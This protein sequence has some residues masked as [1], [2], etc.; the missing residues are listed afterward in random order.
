[1]GKLP[2]LTRRIVP[3]A[4]R[5]SGY[6][7][8]SRLSAGFDPPLAADRWEAARQ[9]FEE[10]GFRP[11]GERLYD[12]GGKEVQTECIVRAG[13]TEDARRIVEIARDEG[14]GVMAIGSLTSAVGAFESQKYAELYA[15]EGY[16][17][18]QI[19]PSGKLSATMD[20]E[21]K[22]GARFERLLPDQREL[23]GMLELYRSKD[24]SINHRVRVWAGLT[25]GQINTFLVDKLGFGHSIFLDLTTFDSAQI[26]AVVCN[27]SEGPVRVNAKF[28]LK[29]L[30]LINGDGL[31]VRLDGEKAAMQVG[32]GGTA[33]VVTELVLDVIRE[34]HNEFGYFLPLPGGIGKEYAGLVNYL[35]RVMSQLDQYAI[36]RFAEDPNGLKLKPESGQV[37]LK[38]FEIITR[39][40]LRS[41]YAV[42][43]EDSEERGRIGSL[44]ENMRDTRCHVG[45]LI[46]CSTDIS[47]DEMI[48][49]LEALFEDSNDE[50]N[51][52]TAVR[53]LQRFKDVYRSMDH[54]DDTDEDVVYFQPSE[55]KALKRIR[56]AI[57]EMTRASKLRGFTTSTDVNCRITATDPDERKRAYKAIM[58][59]YW[60]YA[61][62]MRDRDFRIYTYGHMHPGDRE[63]AIGGGIDPHVRASYFLEGEDEDKQ[64]RA[65]EAFV[66]LKDRKKELLTQLRALHGHFGISL[67]PGEKRISTDYAKWLEEND[68]D[69]AE[70][71]Y[72]YTMKHGGKTFGARSQI[73]LHA[74]PPRLAGGILNY[75]ARDPQA[76]A[77]TP[78]VE[79][80][81]S[82]ILLWCQNSH[83]SAEGMRVVCETLGLM[84]DW[85]GLHHTERVFICETPE[86]ALHTSLMSLVNFRKGKR[87]V[88][89][90]GRSAD[91]ISSLLDE[92]VQAVVLDDIE[93][94][95][96][97]SLSER[98]KVL[99]AEP[100]EAVG[101]R[102]RKLAAVVI[103]S[104][105][106]FGCG[107]ELGLIVTRLETIRHARII[108]ERNNTGYTHS[109]VEM[110]EKT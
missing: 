86:K 62:D 92:D 34:G 89:L 87:S 107:G 67:E 6:R 5:M 15:L 10:Q 65:P 73:K 77:D 11:L 50:E 109:L 16:I 96:H 80:L 52:F 78:L 100:A 76:E 42:L 49:L 22:D 24:P 99:I 95:G 26:G 29:A 70:E 33:G 30:T 1:M 104:G 101:E 75:F 7:L 40:E 58:E 98:K 91:E 46:N 108:G 21:L 90:R 41:T 94:L 14:Y 59:I 17:G 102:L 19:S 36:G 23:N 3:P 72:R 110:N 93:L 37:L 82:S 88:D 68:P 55:I 97:P 47:E 39:R 71:L 18:L 48:N 79:S 13:S 2:D 83:R 31:T 35:P 45:L 28:N 44:L 106:D 27:G 57:P 63:M 12:D 66:Y 81:Q 51:L 4:I 53:N 61:N 84:R 8:L 38:G 32:L 9:L 103:Y 85:L 54:D 69:A 64:K 105:E 43:N 25:P 60:L 74:H 56:E 20:P